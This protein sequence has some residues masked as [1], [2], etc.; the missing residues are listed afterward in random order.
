MAEPEE[1]EISDQQATAISDMLQGIAQ[2]ETYEVAEESAGTEPEMIGPAGQE[3]IVSP[4]AAA[5]EDEIDM[6]IKLSPE[7]IK[8]MKVLAILGSPQVIVSLKE[9]LQLTVN[10]VFDQLIQ[11]ELRQHLASSGVLPEAQ[12]QPAMPGTTVGPQ[13]TARAAQAAQAAVADSFSHSLSNDE[14]DPPEQQD[15]NAEQRPMQL[16]GQFP[17]VG[18]DADAHLDAIYSGANGAQQLTR[19]QSEEQQL[20]AL[21][22]APGIVAG[23]GGMREATK[24]HDGKRK[25]NVS[26]ARAGELN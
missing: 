14:E 1:L 5:A 16:A 18:E 8:R 12:L 7:T 2:E 19:Q 6:R 15:P 23:T 20:A 21:A 25:A 10:D 24:A 4:V 9:Q 26:V 11:D 22:G 17:D 13:P 3:Q